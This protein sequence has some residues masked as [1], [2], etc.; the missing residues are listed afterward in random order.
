MSGEHHAGCDAGE[1]DGGADEA[2]EPPSGTVAETDLLRSSVGLLGLALGLVLT[3]V[4]EVVGFLGGE[5]H[6][7]ARGP[8]LVVGE[9][10]AAEEVVV[11]VAGTVPLVD[12]VAQGHVAADVVAALVD[13]VAQ[14]L[15]FPQ[16]GFMRHLQGGRTGEL[17][18][19][20]GEK[21]VPAE[22]IDDGFHGDQ[23]DVE[24]DDLGRFHASAAPL[25]GLGDGDEPQEQLPGRRL[26]LAG[27][28]RVD[29]LGALLERAQG[30]THGPVGVEGQGGVDASIEEL[31]QGELEDRERT[32][33][34][35]HVAQELGQQR[36]FQ[37]DPF[38]GH[39]LLGRRLPVRLAAWPRR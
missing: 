39:G 33:L 25:A 8:S 11:G 35:D 16:Q 20:E 3:R 13:P 37:R 31:G 18:A 10:G 15:P 17:I 12:G 1:C 24:R 6:G 28:L 5:R 4:F 9:A 2:P 7:R 30:A 22:P 27:E 32:W 21:P 29:A 26:L 14:P 34:A 19:V 23:V 36:R 38:A